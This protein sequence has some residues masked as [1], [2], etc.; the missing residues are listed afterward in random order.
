MATA[1]PGLVRKIREDS[2]GLDLLILLLPVGSMIGLFAAPTAIRQAAVFAHTRPTLVAAFSTHYAH[3]T[4]SHLID[5]LLIYGLVVPTTYVLSVMADRR[6]LYFVVLLTF[7]VVFPF[8]LTASSF[9]IVRRGTLTGFSA[10][11]MAFGGFL[12]VV[13]TRY[14][15][16]QFRGPIDISQSPGLFF[17]GL[18][19]VAYLT[20]PV[21]RFRLPLVGVTALIG[22]AYLW[23]PFQEIN[24]SRRGTV[25][26]V[27]AKGG[28]VELV[29][30]SLLAYVIALVVGFHPPSDTGATVVNLYLQFLGFSFG[31]IGSYITFRV[32]RRLEM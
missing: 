26:G 21:Q 30:F 32:D 15:D 5:N 11:G 16:Q 23:R 29:V 31:F 1:T 24:R 25:F 19:V 9:V 27:T 22:I 3:L 28:Y 17:L 14:L 2:H 8:V 18:S 7:L 4:Q 12:P 13:L 20:V 6:Q 10:I